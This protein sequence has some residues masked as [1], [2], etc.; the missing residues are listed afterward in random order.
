MIV[1]IFDQLHLS[2]FLGSTV[3][4]RDGP[5]EIKQEMLQNSK[6]LLLILAAAPVKLKTPNCFKAS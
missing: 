6:A 4:L 2:R 3:L 5:K 1:I